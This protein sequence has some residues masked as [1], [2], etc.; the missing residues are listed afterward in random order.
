MK[1]NPLL[2]F[3]YIVIFLIALHLLFLYKVTLLWST[4]NAWWFELYIVLTGTYLLSR[5]FI[6]YFYE[7]D[8][9]HGKW[10]DSDYPTVS[11]V[12]AG[13]DEGDS[14]FDT[15]SAIMAS[16]Y[17]AWFEC[18]AV[19]DGSTDTTLSEMRRAALRFGKISGGVRVISFPV[20][21]GKREGMA[22]GVL[23]AKG[24]I[25]VFVDSDSFL[26]PD[27][28]KLIV[29][30]FL[31]NPKVGAVSG[32]TGVANPTTNMLTRMQS[33]RY[34]V[35]FDIFKACES[36]FGVVTCCP[37]CFS[38]YRRSA[39]LEILQ[40]W[41][42]K[43]FLG[44]PSTFG[45]DRSLTNYILLKKWDVVYCREAKATTIV[46]DTYKKYLKQQVRW[47]K[48]W[49]RE[50]ITPAKFIW[51]RNPIA[52]SSFYTNLLI[53]IFSPLIAI[54]ALFIQPVFF[55]HMPVV[56]LTGIIALSVLLGL[57]NFIQTNSRYWFYVV[58]F[59]LFYVVVHLWQMPY[60]LF[61]LKNTSW[62]TR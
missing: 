10:K 50:G 27:A 32:N 24:E 52:S 51:R 2:N 29:E 39:L 44:T 12:I 41:R 49:I 30:H 28:T 37:G 8:H 23:G 18:L 17:P 54:N 21:R 31:A 35:S 15:I 33:A 48:S 26:A 25:I 38:A 6:V 11:F 57:F 56:F 59:S 62:G 19:D 34:S 14:I 7:D 22:E 47:K 13:K 4:N 43:T 40:A 55:M 61:H 45:D 36:V 5:F 20:N 9:R 46:P 16:D 3:I 1:R 60:A 42:T 58:I 53:P